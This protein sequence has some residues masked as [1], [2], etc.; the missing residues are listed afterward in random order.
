MISIIIPVF[1]TSR[2]LSACLNSIIQQSHTDWEAILV[3]D[4]STDKSG[5]ICDAFAKKDKRFKVLH[6][7]NEGVDKARFDGIALAKGDLLTFVDSDD[8][9]EKDYLLVLYTSL[10]ENNADYAEVGFYRTLGPYKQKR[11][12][13]KEHQGLIEQPKLFNEYF[14]T[15]FGCHKLTTYLWGKLFRRELFSKY[16]GGPSGLRMCEDY[17]ILIQIFPYL[18]RIY[19]SDY[20][21]YNYRFG[22]VTSN[23]MHSFYPNLKYLYAYKRKV[24]EK[25][26][27]NNERNRVAFYSV[28]E[29][30]NILRTEVIDRIYYG[31][32]KEETIKFISQEMKEDMWENL[33]YLPVPAE[34]FHRPDVKAIALKDAETYY[35]IMEE[36]NNSQHWK[37]SIKCWVSKFFNKLH[38][39]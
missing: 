33:K 6:K 18:N 9:I 3:D 17:L 4:G 38:I 39:L 2:F 24:M 11:A 34:E 1:N 21:G 31:R 16:V 5:D 23:Y 26:N 35:S 14:V 32:N 8:T 27:Y 25:Y 13:P 15:F 29:M 19:L 28:I 10:V 12:I 30:V 20:I 7:E 22:G 37:R 36:I